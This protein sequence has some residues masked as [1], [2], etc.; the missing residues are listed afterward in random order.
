MLVFLPPMMWSLPE[1]DYKFT[2]KK[3]TSSAF[4]S[5]SKNED[6]PVGSITRQK[7]SRHC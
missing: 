3:E 7:L 5:I 1:P 2:Q 6:V 4:A